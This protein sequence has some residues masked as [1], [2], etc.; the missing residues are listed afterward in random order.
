MEIKV[1]NEKRS[2][3]RTIH[4]SGTEVSSQQLLRQV[5]PDPHSD[6]RLKRHPVE[7]KDYVDFF[8][9]S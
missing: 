2:L 3:F 7:T 1:R 9:Q 6:C 5:D 8:Y 4:K